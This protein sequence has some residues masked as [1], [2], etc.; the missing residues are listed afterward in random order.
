VEDDIVIAP[1][2]EAFRERLA[3]SQFSCS[4]SPLL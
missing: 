4:L 3:N 1:L 2:S